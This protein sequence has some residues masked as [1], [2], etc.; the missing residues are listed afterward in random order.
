M[1]VLG[2]WFLPESWIMFVIKK[3]RPIIV[4]KIT[5]SF[6]Q[7]I[8]AIANL[9]I[10]GKFRDV[11]GK[12][13]IFSDRT[14]YLLQQNKLIDKNIYAIDLCKDVVSMLNFIYQ[15][16]MVSDEYE[17]AFRYLHH[18]SKL[19]EPLDQDKN[20]SE[21][22]FQQIEQL[23]EATLCPSENKD[24]KRIVQN[25]FTTRAFS[26]LSEERKK[27]EVISNNNKKELIDLMR[28]QIN[29]M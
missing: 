10:D 3:T 29:G 5:A 18:Y 11:N 13:T 27:L 26:Y 28:G 22:Y 12:E 14:E 20:F 25:A 1:L 19:I 4:E 16:D 24:A 21:N 17:Q 2:L 15:N 6:K 8:N 7:F 9:Y 23:A